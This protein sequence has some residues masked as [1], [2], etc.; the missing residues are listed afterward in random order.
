M[1]EEGKSDEGTE[2]TL[3]AIRQGVDLVETRIC[4]IVKVA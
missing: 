3:C 2:Q 4:E 1:R